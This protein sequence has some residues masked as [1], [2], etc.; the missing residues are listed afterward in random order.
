MNVERLKNSPAG[1]TK[2]KSPTG[3]MVRHFDDLTS[4]GVRG[5]IFIL[6]DL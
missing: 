1:P 5:K 3:R 4:A 6:Y 2:S